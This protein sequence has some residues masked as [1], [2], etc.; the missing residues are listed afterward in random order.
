MGAVPGRILVRA[1]WSPPDVLG[2]S[3]FPCKRPMVVPPTPATMPQMNRSRLRIEARAVRAQAAE[4]APAD[5][6]WPQELWSAVSRGHCIAGYWAIGSEISPVALLEN[7]VAKGNSVCLPYFTQRGSEMEFRS[8]V[9]EHGL[10]ASPFTFA[11][12]PDSSATKI[13]DCLLIPTLA[14]DRQGNRIGQGGGH[15]DR[16]LSRHP[17]SLRIGL[18]WWQQERIDIVPEAWDIPLHAV[19][20]DREWI[21][22][23]IHEGHSL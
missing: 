9:P 5:L 20:T 23:G 1:K 4:K 11:Q 18:A 22:C 6:V 7:L 10:E 8:W 17:A 12:P 13:P 15:Y 16:Y 14:F 21:D 2:V 3:G 19:V